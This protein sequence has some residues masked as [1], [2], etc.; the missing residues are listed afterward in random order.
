M[1]NI[2]SNTI[3]YNSVVLN[4]FL[5]LSS[6]LKNSCQSSDATISKIKLAE[7]GTDENLMF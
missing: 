6:F 4:S 3:S 2:N 7:N 1:L 5:L